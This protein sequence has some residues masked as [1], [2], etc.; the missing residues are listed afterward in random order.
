MIVGVWKNNTSDL[1]LSF[2]C[3]VHTSYPAHEEPVLYLRTY[4]PCKAGSRQQTIKKE[5]SAM[6]ECKAQ[7]ERNIN[8]EVSHS[9]PSLLGWQFNRYQNVKGIV[10]V[11]GVCVSMWCESERDRQRKLYMCSSV[12][13]IW[14]AYGFG[15]TSYNKHHT[16]DFQF[17][18]R[19]N[20]T[21]GYTRVYM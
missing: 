7:T 11:N 10:A 14:Y 17:M 18:V 9:V 12:D 20:V 3:F 4:C 16:T 8:T 19:Q 21:L 1:G 15:I 13:H 2:I 5:S 6:Q